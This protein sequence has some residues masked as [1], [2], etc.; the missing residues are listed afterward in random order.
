[1]IYEIYRP[2]LSNGV[3]KFVELK[4]I[5]EEDITLDVYVAIPIYTDAA[6]TS[7]AYSVTQNGHLLRHN[8]YTI[9]PLEA[10]NPTSLSD[11]LELRI[12][13][14]QT[15]LNIFLQRETIDLNARHLYICADSHVVRFVVLSTPTK[16]LDFV[17][18]EF[19]P[20]QEVMIERQ[21]LV[22]ATTADLVLPTL[23]VTQLSE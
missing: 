13:K 23:P 6:S 22:S 10:T 19:F 5:I 4:G 7:S 3:V 12:I 8:T 21:D 1:M 18:M 14:E 15:G 16:P 9:H 2:R 11:E 17:N 20:T